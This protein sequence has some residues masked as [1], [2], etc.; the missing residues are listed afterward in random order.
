[1]ECPSIRDAMAGDSRSSGWAIRRGFEPLTLA[2]K[3]SK[4]FA[5]QGLHGAARTA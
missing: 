5:K 1:M 3:N 4:L 2:I